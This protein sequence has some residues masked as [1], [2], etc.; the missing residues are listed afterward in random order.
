MHNIFFVIKK[1]QV[2]G[3]DAHPSNNAYQVVFGKDTS[4]IFTAGQDNRAKQWIGLGPDGEHIPSHG[5]PTPIEGHTDNVT[6]LA[7]SRDG[8]FLATGSRDRTIR[9]WDLSSTVPRL[10][11]VYQGHSEEVE[12]ANTK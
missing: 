2:T 5:K 4:V 9:L 8:K 10:A 12:R 11:R 3:L 7:V 1:R 6:S